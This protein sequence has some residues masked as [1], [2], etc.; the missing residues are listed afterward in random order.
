MPENDNITPESK[1]E[2]KG[3]LV[4]K[5]LATRIKESLFVT[6]R[7][8]LKRFVI[9]EVILPGIRDLFHDIFQRGTE[10]LFYGDS[11]GRRRRSRG[12]YGYRG[13]R[14]DYNSIYDGDKKR[15][16]KSASGY[17]LDDMIFDSKFDA[18]EVFEG[19]CERL[20]AYDV[21]TVYDF[22]DLSGETADQTDYNWGW[23]SLEGTQIKRVPDGWCIRMPRPV[24]LKD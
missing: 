1:P 12:G 21:V 18:D 19:L 11:S 13:D 2:S 6:S 9:G 8:E 4:K 3:H 7:E 20:E 24:H 16:T 15:K 14:T 5:P 23:N 10:M 22:Y 17:L